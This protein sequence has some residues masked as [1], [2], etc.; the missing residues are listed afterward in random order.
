MDPGAANDAVQVSKLQAFLKDTEGYDVAVNG[1]FDQKTEAAVI[2]FQTK[3]MSDIMGPWGATKA[4]GTVYITTLKKINQIACNTALN[5]S[6]ADLS[7]IDAYR[8]AEASGTNAGQV[9]VNQNANNGVA[10]G[11]SAPTSASSS[12]PGAANSARAAPDS[13]ASASAVSFASGMAK[14]MC[15]RGA[16]PSSCTDASMTPRD[17]FFS[18]TR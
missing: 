5:L 1:S 10:V 18:C 16:A 4:S 12:N 14:T 3:Y 9:G 17:P 7:V 15:W 6:V 13:S 8:R 11:L 2:A